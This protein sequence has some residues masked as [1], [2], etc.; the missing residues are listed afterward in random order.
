MTF[1]TPHKEQESV[2]LAQGSNEYRLV[3][4]LC[5]AALMFIVFYFQRKILSSCYF[6]LCS[7]RSNP[8][9]RMNIGSAGSLERLIRGRERGRGLERL[10]LSRLNLLLMQRDFDGNDYEVLSRLDNDVE[11]QQHFGASAA[12]IGRLPTYSVS[13]PM[14]DGTQDSSV[15]N[16]C[17]VCL[18]I[19]E[20]G[21]TNRILPCL[22]VF[23][24]KCIDTWLHEHATCP[25]CKFSAIG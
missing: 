6:W 22:H 16:Q 9:R 3:F 5:L 11:S 19:F 8:S 10:S 7:P 21:D 17:S 20:V 15:D 4:F 2:M 23:H 24:E 1:L 25:I 18:G 14:H 13:A 12:E